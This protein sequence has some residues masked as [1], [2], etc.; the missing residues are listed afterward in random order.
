[1]SNITYYSNYRID[2]PL[3]GT[4]LDVTLPVQG[5]ETALLT[6]PTPGNTIA[7]SSNGIFERVPV[8]GWGIAERRLSAD[9]G[10][11]PWLDIFYVL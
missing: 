4:S 7:D 1:M 2:I 3:K 10:P 5:G 9:C 6:D 11:F 8:A